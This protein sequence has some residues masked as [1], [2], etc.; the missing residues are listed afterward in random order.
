[1]NTLLAPHLSTVARRLL[2]WLPLVLAFSPHAV[3]GQTLL[4]HYPMHGDFQDVVGSHHGSPIGISYGIDR[5]GTPGGAG[6]FNG[7]SSYA[8]IGSGLKP[9]FP[10]TVTSW[11][12]GYGIVLANDRVD[13]S[14]Y[15]FEL[16]WSPTNTDNRWV[17]FYSGSSGPKT[18]I[19]RGPA[20]LGNVDP[21]AWHHITVV[22]HSVSDTEWFID[23][24]AYG[25]E[26]MSGTGTTMRYSTDGHGTVGISL[27][28]PSNGAFN[29]SIDELRLYSGALTLDQVARLAE[30]DQLPRILKAPVSTNVV[31]GSRVQFSVGSEFS[32]TAIPVVSARQQR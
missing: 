27:P 30:F 18:R 8:D 4:A 26:L 31:I 21:Q 9:A 10:I 19:S 14:R 17:Q 25:D 13:Q 23:G 12:K 1:M 5:N 32:G 11:V 24:R 22:M 29:G 2:V 16:Y 6:Q 15:G 7:I 28:P 20:G 3:R